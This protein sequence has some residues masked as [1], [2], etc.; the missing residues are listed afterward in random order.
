MTV[1]LTTKFGV[2]FVSLIFLSLLVAPVLGIVSPDLSGQVYQAT[3]SLHVDGNPVGMEITIDGRVAG[4]VGESGVLV[5]D[6]VPVGEHTLTAS[7]PDYFTKELVVNVPDGLPAEVRVTLEK[8]SQ[9]TLIIESTPPNVQVYVDDLY[10][11]VTPVTLEAEIGSHDVLLR[12]AGYK[13]WRTEVTVSAE[14][15]AQV[16]GSLEPVAAS[17]VPTPKAGPGLFSSLLITGICCIIACCMQQ[18]RGR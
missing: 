9:G 10:K 3:G 15:P 4:Q 8:E 14:T 5:I 17:P 12:L 13:D 2:G 6:S 18:G 16:S 1:S 7:H 11:G